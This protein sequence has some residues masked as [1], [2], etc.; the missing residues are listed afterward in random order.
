MIYDSPDATVS[1]TAI[2]FLHLSSDCG[3]LVIL[4]KHMWLCELANFHRKKKAIL[5]SI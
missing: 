1:L 5:L 2:F 4:T 3:S